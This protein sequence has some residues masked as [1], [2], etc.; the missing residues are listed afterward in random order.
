[1]GRF[2]Y[3][4]TTPAPERA[5]L[6]GVDFGHD[7]AWP[8]EESLDELGRLAETDG[9][10]VVMR[11]TQ[12]LDAPVPRTF[13]GSGKAAEL[14]TYVRNLDADIVIFDDE[15]SPSQQA[16]L[17]KIIGEPTSWHSFSTSIRVYAACGATLRATK[18]AAALAAA[19]VWA[20][21]SSR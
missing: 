16:N 18:R 6:V 3:R 9:A 10:E 5:I 14:V 2:K 19:S 15:L 20:K 21:V 8:I 11:V 12:K 13:I 1:M 17:E 4:S 7:D